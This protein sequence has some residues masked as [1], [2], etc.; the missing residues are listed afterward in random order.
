MCQARM[1]VKFSSVLVWTILCSLTFGF[2]SIWCLHFVAMLAC[3]LDLP[4]GINISLTLLSAVLAVIFTFAA[5]ASDLLWDTYTRDRRKRRHRLA[6]R[7]AANGIKKQPSVIMQDSSSSALLGHFEEEEERDCRHDSD[8]LESPPL[9]DFQQE[10]YEDIA[11]DVQEAPQ[12]ILGLLRTSTRFDSNNGHCASSPNGSPV[13]R[14]LLAPSPDPHTEEPRQ[15]HDNRPSLYQRS[16]SEHSVS[17]RSDSFMSSSH[18]TY[19]LSNIVNMAYRSTAPAKNAFIVTG[20]ALFAGC[21]L[22][23][24][25]KG[26]FWSLAITSMHYVGIYALRIPKGHFTL[27]P[28]LVILS[29]LISW[30]VCLIGCIL[31]S[32]IET[33]FT[34]QFLFAAVA[35]I[36]VAAMHFT[37][38]SLC[39]FISDH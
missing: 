37:G 9:E 28:P 29:A 15:G 16:S 27:N 36:G 30:I 34:Q 35:C 11:N 22:R 23:N 24:I 19:G 12:P 31:M 25:V 3:E 20:E 38:T 13:G 6:R 10:G 7:G 18:S 14:K 17:Q 1:S 8:D 4:I 32:Q 33:H 39:L 21:T 26:F 5:L 2:C